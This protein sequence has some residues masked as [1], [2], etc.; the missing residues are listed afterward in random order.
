[1]FGEKKQELY[2]GKKLNVTMTLKYEE[3]KK[4]AQKIIDQYENITE[5]DFWILKNYLSY[6]D[7]MGYSGLIISHNG[8][9]KLNDELPDD[10]KFKPECVS[11]DKDGYGNS[12]VFMY[13]SPEQGIFE[14]G[15]A[16]AKNTTQA[17]PYAMAYKR[18]Y[19]RVVLKN[20]KLAYGGIYSE[21]EAEEFKKVEEP[22]PSPEEQAIEDELS[23]DCSE[24]QK[25]TFKKACSEYG[26]DPNAVWKQTGKV[27]DM[28][29]RHM[30]LAMKWLNEH[31]SAIGAN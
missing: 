22:E 7:T 25:E 31:A 4:T 20:S 30:G 29:N 27:K 28:S 19:D 26:V 3:S 21:V 2:K 24:A 11:Y 23:K 16:S 8:C 6:N 18:L 15:E 13:C 5:A 10:K 17:Y 9:L 12:L 1:M 14:V